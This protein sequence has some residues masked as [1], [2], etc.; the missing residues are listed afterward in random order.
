MAELSNSVLR[1]LAAAQR[2]ADHPEAVLLS[3]F[4]EGALTSGE[5]AGVLAHLALCPD[6]REVLS[7]ATAAAAE[8]EMQPVHDAPSFGSWLLRRKAIVATACACLLV[9]SV[10][11]LRPWQRSS[12]DRFVV[13]H[14]S[15]PAQGAPTASPQVAQSSASPAPAATDQISEAR[16]D[17][18]RATPAQVSPLPA[19][20][21]GVAYGSGTAGRLQLEEQGPTIQ[22]RVTTRGAGGAA[23][24]SLGGILAQQPDTLPSPSPPPPAAAPAVTAEAP[25]IA[26][27]SYSVQQSTN[28][29]QQ[30]A[31]VQTAGNA[32]FATAVSS[33]QALKLADQRDGNAPRAQ[34]NP[35][36]VPESKTESSG[37]VRSY[38]IV[39]GNVVP[40]PPPV[41]AAVPK[42]QSSLA[43]KALTKPLAIMRWIISAEGALQRSFDSGRSWETV[44]VGAPVTFRAADADAIGDHVWAGGVGAAL[45]RSSDG[46]QSWSR[47]VPA[48]GSRTLTGDIVSVK[49]VGPDA[50]IVRVHTS[51]GQSWVSN[52]QGM[53][54]QLEE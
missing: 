49:T 4:A 54:W 35:A 52:D 33:D 3:A 32:G 19:P 48:A 38:E 30:S 40:A 1:R 6:C 8:P 9:A 22:A 11:L 46:G 2:P 51:T 50:R 18:S 17:R 28:T 31:T 5:R 25:N 37:V 7:L 14:T 34:S 26:L 15:Q 21:M 16:N 27:D 53:H 39:N 42:T 20:K 41:L 47:V 13:A 12:S 24:G 29:T 23:G 44:S 45:Y 43:R 36:S 10:V